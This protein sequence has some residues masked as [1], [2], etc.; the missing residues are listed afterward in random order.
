MCVC[1]CAF[2]CIGY[3]CLCT[4]VRRPQVDI[5]YPPVLEFIWVLTLTLNSDPRLASTL[6][7]ESSEPCLPMYVSTADIWNCRPH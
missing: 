4:C 5:R 6:I 1:T 3:S 7:T 2:V